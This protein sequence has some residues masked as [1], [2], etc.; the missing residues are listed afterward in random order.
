MNQGI[1]QRLLI[2]IV[3]M[4]AFS[5][6]GVLLTLVTVNGQKASGIVINLAGA[7]RMLSQKM[8]KEA[9]LL[10]AN[11]G[12]AKELLKSASRFDKVYHGLIQGDTELKLPACSD[13]EVCAL[14]AKAGPIWTPFL[15]AVKTVAEG[16]DTDGKALATLA[17]RNTELLA[18]MHAVVL[19]LEVVSTSTSARLIW[20]QLAGVLIITLVAGVVVKVIRDIT[21]RLATLVTHAEHLREGDF[22]K[23]LENQP[24]DEIGALAEVL[25]T[26]TRRIRTLL[27]GLQADADALAAA[28]LQLNDTSAAL[29]EEAQQMSSQTLSISRA[30]NELA[31][32]V[33]GVSTS[34]QTI[35]VR[36]ET[37]A[38]AVEQMS[39]SIREVAR[40]ATASHSATAAAKQRVDL[41]LQVMQVLEESTKRVRQVN[42]AIQSIASQT[43]LLA[44]NASIEAASA[45]KAGRGFSIVAQE[46]KA[47]ATQSSTSVEQVGKHLSGIMEQVE[48]MRAV[49]QE[50]DQD[51][52]H[53]DVLSS[54]L[55]ASAE[56]Q[57][58]VTHHISEQL[59]GVSSEV[60]T[61]HGS[62]GATAQEAQVVSRDLRG[63]Q[64]VV[65]ATKDGA[66]KTRHS[67]ETLQQMA[68]RMREVVGQFSL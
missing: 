10:A 63:I 58:S 54:N 60:N 56:E 5:L 3:A 18:A 59:H 7:Q 46:V 13:P 6:I 38:A 41:S 51:V 62:V 1:K 11:T 34:V 67:A 48:R 49:L 36:T 19:R 50:I 32:E 17:S 55:A 45:G 4:L 53:V 16:R 35:N 37:V 22:R 27:S 9:L 40:S 52:I 42:S 66:L 31:T 65:D 15:E 57:T 28:S 68:G 43:R 8:T 64:R 21:S 47:L 12:D 23:T 30:S 44:L 33:Q 14:L 24:A 26:M 61:L 25:N 29:V 20:E 2:C 39:A